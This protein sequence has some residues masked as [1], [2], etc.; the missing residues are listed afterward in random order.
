[1]A[2]HLHRDGDTIEFP[3]EE[4]KAMARRGELRQD[5]YVYDDVKAEWMGAAL[6]AEL[7]GAWNIEEEE[8][9]VAIQ[10]PSDFFEKFDEEVKA[11]DPALEDA[12]T[13]EP[14][15]SATVADASTEGDNEATR[16]MDLSELE[17]A[18]APS[19]SHQDEATVA[20]D[21]S[22]HDFD[23]MPAPAPLPTPSAPAPARAA[24]V[25]PAPAAAASAQHRPAPA[26][27]PSQ[28]QPAMA[29][30][31]ARRPQ[32]ARGGGNRPVGKLVNP[33][34]AALFGFFSCNIY[35]LVWV[36]KRGE[37]T[38]AFVG[39]ERLARWFVPAIIAIVVLLGGGVGVLTA[40]FGTALGWLPAAAVL[41]FWGF[42]LGKSVNE[43]AAQSGVNLGDR[44][45]VYAVC[46][47]F[48]PL[49]LFLG[50]QDLN[51]IWRANGA[52]E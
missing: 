45:V 46:A 7:D 39:E 4:L 28:R 44:S 17:G 3:L 33:V 41:A 49:L 14:V 1:M 9:T 13:K 2:F 52:V 23:A 20:M 48:A 16:A 5:E 27:G 35:T 50:Q 12:T 18:L 31:H 51:A 42:T 15:G 11:V 34:L 37:E 30:P 38:N 24:P 19:T 10:L 8:S 29:R 25:Q 21:T 22:G 6:V 43:M 26:R 40:G 47:L 36:W 32:T